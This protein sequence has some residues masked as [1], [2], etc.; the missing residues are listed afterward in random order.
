ML[1]TR[2]DLKEHQKLINKKAAFICSRLYGLRKRDDLRLNVNLFKV[3]I[4]PS[5]RLAWTLFSR[6]TEAEQAG[7]VRHLRVWCKKFAL[8]PVNTA[9]HTFD[10]IFGDI[11]GEI[12]KSVRRTRLK[13]DQRM[14][15]AG[16]QE[17]PATE[18]RK[19][20]KFLPRN[21]SRTLRAI[22]SS[23]CREHNM[24]CITTTHLR[25]MHRRDIDTPALLAR[26]Q[27]KG[28]RRWVKLA[29][30]H[31]EQYCLEIRVARGPR[32]GRPRRA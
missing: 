21:L 10:L 11:E 31:E 5:Y 28:D 25:E 19:A 30:K 24:I 16:A 13:L 2:L 29:L 32:L 6:Q 20:L 22:Y 12:A 1:N 27:Q 17:A 15:I 4:L 9:K 18:P 14:G 23:R 26:Y 3:F 7:L 8:I